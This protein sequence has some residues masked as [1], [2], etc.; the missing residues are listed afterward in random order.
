MASTA[1][2]L[3]PLE[4]AVGQTG[5]P[6]VEQVAEAED[7]GERVG[8]APTAAARA[9]KRARQAEHP[10]QRRSSRPRGAGR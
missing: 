7:A 4:H 2:E 10:G 8:P 5:D 3:D 9:T 1:A 6:L